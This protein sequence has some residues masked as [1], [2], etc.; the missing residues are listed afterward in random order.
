MTLTTLS[1]QGITDLTSQHI[2]KQNYPSLTYSVHQSTSAFTDVLKQL[3]WLS[4][5][6]WIGELHLVFAKLICQAT[7]WASKYV[8]WIQCMFLPPVN[9]IISFRKAS[10]ILSWFCSQ[11]LSGFFQYFC[12]FLGFVY[13]RPVAWQDFRQEIN[14]GSP[15]LFRDR[16]GLQ[17]YFFYIFI[18]PNSMK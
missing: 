6:N 5:K 15:K 9:L 12:P 4:D 10:W 8:F 18:I 1:P 3:P 2:L 7:K 13:P 14:G 11:I 16:V 17:F